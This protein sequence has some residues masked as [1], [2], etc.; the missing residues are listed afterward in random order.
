MDGQKIHLRHTLFDDDAIV[1]ENMAKAVTL[2]AEKGSR[3]VKVEYPQMDYLGIWHAPGTEAPYICI[4][5]W[6]SLPSRKGII[7]D[8]ETQENLIRLEKGQVYTNRWSITCGKN[9]K[10]S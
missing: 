5:P 2:S 6:S 8:L 7:E 9:S 1:M 3:Y 4:E 10:W